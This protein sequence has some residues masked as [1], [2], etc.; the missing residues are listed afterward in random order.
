MRTFFYGAQILGD[1]YNREPS[2]GG[3]IT[4]REI[5]KRI[6]ESIDVLAEGFVEGIFE[7]SDEGIE[8]EEDVTKEEQVKESRKKVYIAVAV[9]LIAL[10]SGIA[11]YFTNHFY[12]GSEIN[13]ISVSGK[14]LKSA[15]EQLASGLQA[16]TLTLVERSGST[17][18]ITGS[19]IGLRNNS[20]EDLYKFKERQ[21]PFRWFLA[22]FK[23]EDYKIRVQVVYDEKRLLKK[24]D[25]LACFEPV[26]VIEPKNPGFVCLGK[27]FIVRAEDE[28]NKI[29]KLLLSSKIAEA[30]LNG[31]TKLDLE[32]ADCYVK[33][34]YTCLSSEVVEAK[35]TLNKYVFSE[36]IYKFG[37]KEE[38]VDGLTINGWLSA[39]ENYEV[40]VDEKKVAEWLRDLAETYDTVGK[41]RNFTA[42][43]GETVLIGGGDYGWVMDVVKET[44]NLMSDV[45]AGRK[46]TKEP[47]Y[48]QTA[49]ER[50]SNDIGNVYVEINIEQQRLWF[51]KD[52]LLMVEGSIV[53]GDVSKHRQ[54]PKGIYRLKYKQRDA[55]LRG[56]DYEAPV[57]YWM[58]FNK[59]IGLHDATWRSRFGGKIYMTN[60]SHGCVNLPF[61]VAEIIFDNI[62]V[63]TP[64]IVY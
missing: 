29:N 33:P 46:V 56:P 32:T 38:V 55:I 24:I 17:E 10:Y 15:Q 13:A 41:T 7:A 37:E 2:W 40:T 8:G 30:I 19:D 12:F 6:E 16:Y 53:T 61:S 50:K 64:V 23:G 42:S 26:N 45:K 4:D 21:D 51:Y 31:E 36:I 20:D 25:S 47:A 48:R 14:S 5:E 34:E 49:A 35:N 54:T 44:E 39:D 58:P 11:I 59:G 27:S 18:E 52:G 63:D 1:K 28:G 3:E 62:E 22:P 57:T 60:G 43:T 9:C